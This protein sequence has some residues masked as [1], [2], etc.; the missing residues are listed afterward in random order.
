LVTLLQL[1]QEK[2]KKVMF[3]VTSESSTI[4]RCINN[5]GSLHLNDNY[6]K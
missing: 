4:T 6:S 1:T 2:E 5:H 3:R